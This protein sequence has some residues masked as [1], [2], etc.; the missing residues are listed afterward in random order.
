VVD[1]AHV[2]PD[3]EPALFRQRPWLRG[4]IPHHPLGTFPTAVER[5]EGLLPRGVEL[6]VKRED[7]AGA[8]YGGNKVRKLEFLIARALAEGRERLFTIGG[9][10]SHHAL[11]TAIYARAA[12]LGCELALFPQPASAHVRE[13][14]R[15]DLAAGAEVHAVDLLAA[16]GPR[17]LAARLDRKVAYLTGGGSSVDGTF[18]WVSAADELREQIVSGAL[19]RPDAIY[20]AL[21]SCGTAAGLLAGFSTFAVHPDEIVGVR[22]V[23]RPISGAGPTRTLAERTFARLWPQELPM[24]P[25]A[26]LRVEHDQIG[27]G[28]GHSTPAAEAAVAAAARVGLVL[29]TTYTGKAMAQLFADAAS[30]R[31]DRKRVLFLHTYSSVDLGPLLAHTPADLPDGV[32]RVLGAR[33]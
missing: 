22:V 12:G 21:G 1:A 26:D 17:V 9:W 11:A 10:G 2:P 14:L 19:P 32:R 20:L 13:Q 29:E 27:A 7:R 15:A 16:I 24:R 5:V 30:G 25:Y 4:V 3:A 8:L 18:G 31:L 6:W 28:Y 33:E 23:D